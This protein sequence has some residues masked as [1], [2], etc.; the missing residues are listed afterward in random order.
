MDTKAFDEFVKRQQE[1]P[2]SLGPI[3]WDEQR[4][5]WLAHLDSLYKRVESFI[6]KY[7]AAGE[8]I[9][10]YQNIELNEENIGA[11]IAK[12]MKLKIGRQIVTLVPIGTLLIGSKGRVDVVGPIGRAQI[13]L[14]DKEASGPASLIHVTVSIGGK[15]SGTPNRPP[16]RI[17]WEWKIA[18]R[19]PDIRFEE[20]TQE[21]F[22]QLILEVAN[23]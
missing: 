13:I 11:Y 1:A 17:N 9:Y 14:V 22:L 20:L 16:K 15:T 12:Q 6:A 5:E 18:T 19:P 10:E 8:M 21:S 4:R 7:V 3:D 23:G 2:S